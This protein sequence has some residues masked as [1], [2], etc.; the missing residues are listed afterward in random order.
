[1][2][3]KKQKQR[4]HMTVIDS[5]GVNYR[6][7]AETMTEM[8]FKMNH[9]SALNNVTRVMRKFAVA[10]ASEWDVEVSQERLD[11]I[12]KSPMF[13]Q[14]IAEILQTLEHERCKHI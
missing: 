7:I 1:M 11:K 2:K 3:I 4:K 9:S 6:D 8:G 5:D 14:G 12:A 10:V 13:Q